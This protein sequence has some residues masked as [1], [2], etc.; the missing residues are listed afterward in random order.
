[1]IE[2]NEKRFC[3]Y[4]TAEK[5]ETN[6]RNAHICIAL[7]FSDFPTMPHF[8]TNLKFATL[9]HNIWVHSSFRVDEFY[10]GL[11]KQTIGKNGRC[12]AHLYYFNSNGILVMSGVQEMIHSSFSSKL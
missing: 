6:E 8:N 3:W 7:Y 1:L 11:I 10:L 4:R 9:S 2:R 5:L 12:L